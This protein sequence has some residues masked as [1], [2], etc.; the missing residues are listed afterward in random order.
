[1]S[2]AGKIEELIAER[3]E[4]RATLTA[5]SEALD[6]LHGM[7]PQQAADVR[8]YAERYRWL[9]DAENGGEFSVGQQCSVCDEYPKYEE[10]AWY[11]DIELDG[12]I[13]AAMQRTKA[14][15]AA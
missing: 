13:D 4:L 5:V 6:Y 3:D 9:R 11:Y 2:Y 12:L 14:V 7:T 10:V 1:M 8:K 15:G